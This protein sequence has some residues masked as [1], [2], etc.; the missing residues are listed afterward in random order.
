M[1]RWIRIDKSAN[2]LRLYENGRVMR[3]YPV[4]TGRSTAQTPE[5]TFTVVFKT[6]N[7]EWRNPETGKTVPGGSPDNPLGTR[8]IGFNAGD[9]RGRTYGIH[10]TREPKSIGH[11]VSHGCIRMQIADVEELYDLTPLGTKVVIVP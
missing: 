2:Q 10:G 5:G 9:P 8:W 7:P 3:E 1:G 4:A 6:W 11:H